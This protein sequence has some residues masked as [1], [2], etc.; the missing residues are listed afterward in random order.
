M[1]DE[2]AAPG[3]AGHHQPARQLRLSGVRP[4]RRD[5]ARRLHPACR[6][7]EG[8]GH[9]RERDGGAPGAARHRPLRARFR[10]SPHRGGRPLRQYPGGGPLPR[11]RVEG[12]HR[13][14]PRGLLRSLE[15][16]P[17]DG[18][19]GPG[20]RPA[21]EARL[22]RDVAG[23]APLVLPRARCGGPRLRPQAP[24]RLR[25][26][27]LPPPPRRGRRLRG[28]RGR[29]VPGVSRRSVDGGGPAFGD[30]DHL[31][32]HRGSG[33]RGPHRHPLVQRR[34]GAA[35]PARRTLRRGGAPGLRPGPLH[36]GRGARARQRR[37]RPRAGRAH[38][39]HGE[40][41]GRL[42]AR[43][44]RIGG[45][46]LRLHQH[47]RRR[48]GVHRGRAPRVARGGRL[49]RHRALPGSAKATA[50]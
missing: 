44:A 45:V 11:A 16:G 3:A 6:G 17:P 29:H 18:G 50:S 33:P 38:L 30:A 41:A 28:D 13:E 2:H 39:H 12:L 4:P 35:R 48:A 46:Q 31:G 5:A 26:L 10:R 19:H 22:R 43:A 20:R 34:R 7:R 1:R 49:P 36:G 23:G 15:R 47:L 42:A 27:R 37:P 21:G 9:P 25:L 8:R 14:Q 24:P 32:V 40:D